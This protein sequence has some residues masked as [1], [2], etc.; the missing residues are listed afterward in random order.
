MIPPHTLDEG[1]EDIMT[2]INGTARRARLTL[3]RLEIV[4][5]VSDATR[6]ETDSFLLAA[7]IDSDDA[8]TPHALLST[9][10]RLSER[11]TY[12]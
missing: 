6:E 7:V 3:R 9:G 4:K 10:S 2:K 12:H 1:S 8:F 5:K 11:G